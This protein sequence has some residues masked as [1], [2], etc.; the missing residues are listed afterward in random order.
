MR[1]DFL[2]P[3]RRVRLRRERPP[4][5]RGFVGRV[6]DLGRGVVGGVV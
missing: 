1:L 4:T 6:G 2:L 5:S 3:L